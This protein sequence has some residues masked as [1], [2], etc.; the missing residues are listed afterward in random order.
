[1]K[2]SKELLIIIFPP[3]RNSVVA[4]V[5]EFERFVVILAKSLVTIDKI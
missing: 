2:A 3:L 5:V 1:M 4:I